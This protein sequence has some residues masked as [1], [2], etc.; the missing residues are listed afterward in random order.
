MVCGGPAGHCQMIPLA[1]ARGWGAR[2][3]DVELPASDA[4][5]AAKSND[6][7]GAA[8]RCDL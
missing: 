6:S 1:E 7:T 3:G 5:P 8:A 2:L 4:V